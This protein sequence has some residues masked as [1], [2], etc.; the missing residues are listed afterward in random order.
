MKRSTKAACLSAF[1]FPGCGHIFL[2][3]YVRGAIFLLITLVGLYF[4]M[5]AAFTIAWSIA[6]DIQLGK[7][8]FNVQSLHS[9]IQQ[10]MGIYQ[11]PSLISAKAAIIISWVISTAD[12]YRV[13]KQQEKASL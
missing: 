1:M 2:K 8:A 11:E 9:V 6:N 12:A 13:G 4:I 5:E 3:C 10:A 7:V